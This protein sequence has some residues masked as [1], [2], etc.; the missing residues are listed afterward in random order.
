MRKSYGNQKTKLNLT[1]KAQKFYN[2]NEI[3]IY[4]HENGY[5]GLE[6]TYKW[7]YGSDPESEPMTEKEL[8][9][10]LE[11]MQDELDNETHWDDLYWANK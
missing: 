4:E 10:L 1:E 5:G 3:K 9:A 6:Y 11:E 2:E 8:N 7:L